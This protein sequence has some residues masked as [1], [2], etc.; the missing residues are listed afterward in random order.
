MEPTDS[1]YAIRLAEDP[2]DLRASQRLRYEVFVEELGGDGEMVDH[3]ARIEQDAFDPFYDH[4]VLVDT[5]R[6]PAN[7]DHVVGVYRLMRSDQMHRVGRFYTADEYD[8][9]PLISS[10][11][12]LLELGRSCVHPDHRGGTA[13]YHLWNG[14]A[15]YV[16]DHDIEILFGVASFHG[17]DA[18]ALAQP[19]AYLHHNHLA[20]EHLRAKALADSY[21]GMERIPA[22]QVNRK[23][24]MLNTPALIKAY[25][26]LGG[27]VGEGAYVDHAFQTTDVLLIM[28]TEL[29]N[30]KSREAFREGRGA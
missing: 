23:E 8:L 30:A 22:D 15:A 3:D 27:V 17:T 14:L 9:S 2:N 28:D 7:L 12:T 10:G 26:R 24:A 19:L 1:Y 21:L 13:M 25:L 5:R 11:R 18:D 29:M 20:P 16:F 6:D 4:M